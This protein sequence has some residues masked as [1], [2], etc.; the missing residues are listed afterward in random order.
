MKNYFWKFV[1]TG[2]QLNV[3]PKRRYS[4]TERTAADGITK[5]LEVPYVSKG[6]VDDGEKNAS[7]VNDK[8]F[9]QHFDVKDRSNLRINEFGIQMINEELFKKLFH[10][11]NVKHNSSDI[12]E[13]IQKLR[14]CNLFVNDVKTVPDVNLKLPYLEGKTIEEYFETIGNK[15]G[16]PYKE[17][18]LELIKGIPEI[19]EKWEM[20]PGWTRYSK[21]GIER[22]DYPPEDAIFLDVEVCCEAGGLPT[23]ATAVSSEAWYGWVSKDLVDG[24]NNLN[25]YFNSNADLIPLESGSRR[26][27]YDLPSSLSK[28]RIA[29]GHNVSFD[30]SKIKEQYW[31]EQTGLRFLDTLS[32]HVCVSG[33]TSYQKALLKAGIGEEEWSKLSSLNSLAK[34]HNLYC[35]KEISK[36]SR[37]LFVTGS[38]EEIKDNFQ[39]AM[40]YCARDVIAT[41]NIFEKLFPMFLER[42][43]HPVTF[44]G[45]LELQ[46]AYLPI[47]KNWYRYLSE[48]QHVF[49]DLD[50]EAKSLMSQCANDSCELLHNDGYKTDLWLWDQ[51][52]TCKNIKLK[53][54]VSKGNGTTFK[55]IPAYSNPCELNL[56]QRSYSSHHEEEF[57]ENKYKQLSDKFATIISKEKLLPNRLPH[58]SGYPEWYRKLC[59]PP[60]SDEWVPEPTL[61]GSGLKITPKLLRL[62][63]KLLPVHYE[64]GA[65]WGYLVPY[66]TAIN[67]EKK[68]LLPLENLKKYF[69]NIHRDELC[70]CRVFETSSYLCYRGKKKRK[71]SKLCKLEIGFSSGLIKLPH[72]DGPHNNVGNPLA[73][74]FVNKFSENALSA[75]S[76]RAKKIL[77][78]NRMLSYWRN[79]R[80][81]IENQFV[82][83]LKSSDVPP[84]LI[85]AGDIGAILPNVIVC[86]TLTRRAVEP[87]W[88]TASNATTERIGSELRSM[89][90]APPGYSLV[91]AD[92]DSQELWIASLLGDA[93]SV[94]LHGATPLGWMTLNG[95]KADGTDMHSVTA[96]AVGISRNH[97]KV[98]NYARIYGAGE[99]FAQRLLKQFKEDLPMSEAVQKAQKMMEL[100]KGRR[101]FKLK[102]NV[103]PDVTDRFHS[104]EA[105]K[106]LCN[107]YNKEVDDLFEKPQWLDGTESAMFNSLEIIANKPTPETPFLNCRL[108]RALEPQ[109][110]GS[111]QH[112]PTRINWVVQSGAVDFLHLML[113]CMRW[114]LGPEPRFCLSFHDEVRYLVKDEYKY[115]TALA[116]HITNLLTR[117]F[118]VS[119]VGMTDL[120]MSVAF[121][122]SVEV[123]KVLRKESK[124]DNKTPSN[125]FGLLKGYGIPLGE[126]LDIYSAIEKANGKVG[127]N[128][129]KISTTNVNAK[130]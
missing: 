28:P 71:S 123:D 79:N 106:K 36:V 22:V 119:R 18:L 32:L 68:L 90:Q 30:R 81:R 53:K 93:Y 12:I 112:L 43:P 110:D 76:F 107:L 126:S 16:N 69:L 80:E 7:S 83:W 51:N 45:M 50:F 20:K 15:L 44:A 62:T 11:A 47:N 41:Y 97:A 111:D 65:G 64:K 91:G 121:F 23:L 3:I 2:D 125:P 1:R 37:D 14:S 120:P 10:K 8:H 55:N 29:I 52:W 56:E 49:E 61:V 21:T 67:V 82:C 108:S 92:V 75:D 89:V 42:F 74:D 33:V 118:C 54:S 98:L 128:I 73:R 130:T 5:V 48:S 101:M 26:K 78:I 94:G 86:G 17:L 6:N 85:D 99:K 9:T 31:L 72:K 122:S 19:P 13:L 34:V 124:D 100:T 4:V 60:S 59:D 27:G 95:Q 104:K 113:V 63:W 87:T 39:E 103:L 24:K 129:D 57:I 35:G 58:L 102:D 77:E 115:E 117:S 25:R 96:K 66:K 70:S 40:T 116:L 109:I 38:L 46:T 114:F 88:M 84:E 127:L 105:A